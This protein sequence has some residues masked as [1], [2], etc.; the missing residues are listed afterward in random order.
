MMPAQTSQV[1]GGAAIALI[2]GAA[3]AAIGSA[4]LTL[5][6]RRH[7]ASAIVRARIGSLGFLWLSFVI[8]Q[9]ILGLVW[10]ALSLA[11]IL[12]SQ[13]IWILCISG[14]LLTCVRLFA[15]REPD[16]R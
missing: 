6:L 10:L 3:V 16:A 2:Y 1:L 11:G 15:H 13:L 4:F 5:V 14:A 9:G 7:R 12:D 8:G